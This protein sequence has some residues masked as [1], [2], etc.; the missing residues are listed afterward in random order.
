MSRNRYVYAVLE[1]TE[2]GWKPVICYQTWRAAKYRAISLSEQN[3]DVVFAVQRSQPVEFAG[4][5]ADYLGG[6]RR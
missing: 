6:V 5:V 4:I 3:G 2:D 1:A